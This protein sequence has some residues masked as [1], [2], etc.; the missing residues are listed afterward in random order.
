MLDNIRFALRLLRKNPGFAALGI[1]TLALGIGANTAMFTVVDSVMLQPLP[2][3]D[4]NKIVAITPGASQSDAVQT[5]S[6]LNYVDLQREARQFRA[7]AAYNIDF[8]ILRTS[9]MSQATAAVKATASLLDVLG[10][11]P[12]LG[13]T[14]V[15]DDNEPGAPAVVMLTAPFWREH[16][17]SDPAVIGQKVR[18]GDQPYTIVGV[19]P[20]DFRF[21]GNDASQGVWIPFQPNPDALRQ[22]NWNLLFVIGSLRPGV[23][24]P[25]A[26]AE[27]ISISRGIVKKDPQH[28]KDLSFRL[29]P[30]RD[31]I[32]S[33]VKEVFIALLGALILVLLIACANVANLQLAR[34]LARA[35]ELAVRTALGASR[36]KLLVQMLV[37]GGVLC[38]FG[39]AVG[40]GLSEVMLAGIR[41]L[42]PDLIPRADEIHFRLSLF[43]M[44]LFA[45][46]VV[47]LLSSV[48]PAVMA[49]LIDPQSLLQEGT[50]GAS[51]GRGRARLSSIMVAGEV[52][53]SVILLVA[54]GL[55]FR[56]LYNLQHIQL[57]FNEE[58]ITS[59]IAFPGD[60]AG[61]FSVKQSQN[62][63]QNDSIALRRFKPLEE[64]LRQLPG[65]MDVGFA[66]VIPFENIDLHGRFAIAGQSNPQDPSSVPRALIR[67]VSGGYARAMKISVVRGRAI[68]D[69]DLAHSPFAVTINATLA[70]RFFPG[71]DPIGQRIN[72]GVDQNEMARNGMPQ[73]YQIVGVMADSLQSQIAQ[74]IEPEIDLPYPQIPVKSVY[75]PLLVTQETNYMVRTHGL[76]EIASAIRELFREAAPDFALDNFQT[77]KAAHEQADFNQRLGLYLVASFAGI[78]VIMVLA[79]LYGV[80]SQLVGQRRHEIAIRMALGANRVSVLVLVLRRGF[81]LMG[82]G[83]AAGLTVAVGVEQSIKSFLYGVSPIDGVTYIGVVIALVLVGTLAAL[84]PAR[85]AAL[86]EPTQAL[87]GE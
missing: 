11:R 56:T 8:A 67:A 2:Y 7:V 51:G 31:V 25:G 22:R 3:P 52:A 59:F 57:G 61:F 10:A 70:R 46:L 13:R 80:L 47:T 36:R 27:L 84:I 76:I 66:S 32:T 75:Y 30:L 44:L 40:L 45:T 4:G 21:A 20:A 34:C 17:G 77:M 29:L 41:R 1:V 28:A 72:F 23:S 37:E 78:A 65:V 60:A 42:P 55:M 26:Q 86:I 12:A 71:Q 39:A 63:D 83:M 38:V 16:F 64:R 18:L 35:Q 33:R 62:L 53:L 81:I 49:T 50:R 43:V 82:F 73:A 68:T 19:L 14:F 5:T 74:P 6:W 79:G 15:A 69:D 48:V 9:E 85:R 58:N 24:L 54:G 87:R